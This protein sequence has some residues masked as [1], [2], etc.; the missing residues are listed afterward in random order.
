MNEKSEKEYQP[1]HI[2]YK[3]RIRNIIISV[4]LLLYGLVGIINNDL[5]LP[6]KRKFSTGEPRGLHIYGIPCWIMFLS[7]LFAVITLLT[8]V[9]DHYDKRDNEI[10]YKRFSRFTSYIALILFFIAG[11]YY[12]FLSDM[13]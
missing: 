13:K 6:L 12:A 11:I 5:Y 2:P 3:E 1:N 8:V 7:F 10:N 4:F 9:F